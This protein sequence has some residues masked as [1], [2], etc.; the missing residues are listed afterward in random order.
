MAKKKK[1]RPISDHASKGGRARKNVLT[2]EERSSIARQAV[3]ARWEKAGKSRA[4]PKTTDNSVMPGPSESAAPE[5]PYSML[6]GTLRIGD[7]ELE[8]HVL[9]DLR[10]VLTQREVVRAISGGRESGNLQRYLSRNPLTANDFD[11]GDV[12]RFKVPGGPIIASGYEATKLI[13]ICSKYTEAR[14]RELLGSTQIKLAIQAGIIL[15]ACAKVGIIALIDEA[16]GY[17]KLRARNALQLKLQAFITDD[18][19][20]WA[21]MFPEE[22]WIQLARLEGVHYSPRNRPLRWGRYVMAFVYDAIDKDVGDKLR[23]LN[24]DPHY[25]KNHHQWLKKYGREAVAHQITGVVT[26]MKLCNGMDQFRERFNHVFKKMPLQT[27][28]EDLN[29]DVN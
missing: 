13:E 6:P 12:I 7:V 14:D 28:F 17:Q 15:R 25:K 10:R 29:W 18:M 16:T 22:F 23:E 20:E 24:P 2:P 5:M 26:I 27:T 11:M 21:R 8:V 3:R 9:N 1:E 4:G 19:Q